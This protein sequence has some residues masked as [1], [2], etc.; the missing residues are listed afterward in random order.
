[1]LLQLERGRGLD[2]W[3]TACEKAVFGEDGEGVDE[4]D[5]DWWWC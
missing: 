3:L 1:M 5:G 4:E 2:F